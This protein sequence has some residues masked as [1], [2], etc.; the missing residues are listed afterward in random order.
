MKSL[1]Y[2]IEGECEAYHQKGIQTK[3][4]LSN[5][6][7]S[8]V[9]KKYIRGTGFRVFINGNQGF[10][11]TTDKNQLEEAAK[12]ASKL[13]KT[14]SEVKRIPIPEE[15]VTVDGICDPHLKDMP[16]ETFMKMALQMLQGAHEK[17]GH[18]VYGSI[19]VLE[20][21]NEITTSYGIT[22]EFH[23]TSCFANIDVEVDGFFGTETLYTRCSG[24]DMFDLGKKAAEL[25]AAS[26]NPQKIEGGKMSIIL[27]PPAVSKLLEN[28][29]VPSLLADNVEDDTSIFLNR[30]G[31]KVSSNITIVDDGIVSGGIGS[32]PFDGEGS[33]CRKTVVIEKGVLQSFL[34]DT[35]TAF[36]YNIKSTG[37]AIRSSFRTPP[38]I[39]I[40]NLALSPEF[41]TYQLIEDTKYGIVVNDIIGSLSLDSIT[42]KF[43]FEAK[44]VFLIENGEI[45]HPTHDVTIA[46]NIRGM[47]RSIE[48]GNDVKQE[49]LLFIPSTKVYASVFV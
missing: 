20:L 42:K 7:I 21:C 18:V 24:F 35:T 23:E 4:V 34:F 1:V 30:I 32:R 28:S 16:L 25:A 9:E 12:L 41:K 29:L 39:Y 33:P 47:L 3:V 48:P 17:G 8:S 45:K 6:C 44:N 11:Y 46:G 49:G 43:G 19:E 13:A 37:N 14:S 5:D 22:G 31:E 38:L 15:Y 40:S 2:S 10:A 27:R 26:R 36:R